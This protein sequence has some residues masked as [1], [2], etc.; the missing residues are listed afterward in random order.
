MKKTTLILGACGQIGTELTLN[1]REKYGNE[2]VVATDIKEPHWLSLKT[3][4]LKFS[5]LAMPPV[6][7]GSL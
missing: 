7:T 4:H 3:V 1:L 5:M 6:C 2:A